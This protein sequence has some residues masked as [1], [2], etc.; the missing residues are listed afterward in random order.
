MADE[1]EATTP[2]V[3]PEYDYQTQI[4]SIPKEQ[5]LFF[6]TNLVEASYLPSQYTDDEDKHLMPDG[7]AR[8]LFQGRKFQ[9]AW[10]RQGQSGEQHFSTIYL[11]P[12][13]DWQDFSS[14]VGDGG[15]LT[16]KLITFEGTDSSGAYIRSDVGFDATQA[17]LGQIGWKPEPVI[18][19]NVGHYKSAHFIIETPERDRAITTLDFD[20]EI[21]GNSSVAPVSPRYQFYISEF[22]RTLFEIK[23]MVNAGQDEL[24]Y[25]NSIYAAIIKKKLD[26][27]QTQMSDAKKLIDDTVSDGNKKVS[28]MVTAGNAKVDD[29]ITNLAKL[30]D[31]NTADLAKISEQI[32][33]SDL[34][35]NENAGTILQ[36]LLNDGKVIVGVPD[37]DND[38][39]LQKMKDELEGNN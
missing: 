28:D 8:I 1:V 37:A 20:L 18:A 31:V 29:F 12:D 26:N 38:A 19:Q 23:D 14:Y 6:C 16:D 27:L 35:T 9:H 11:T 7:W 30:E 34:V 33:G 15:T 21:I 32:K 25:T 5:T 10:I 24:A 4:A 3:T 39:K 13:G 36:Q 22:Q 17:S 2:P